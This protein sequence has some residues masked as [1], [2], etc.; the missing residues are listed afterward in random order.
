[1][2]PSG[3][4]A[5]LCQRIYRFPTP[6]RGPG[7]DGPQS[8]GQVIAGAHPRISWAESAIHIIYGHP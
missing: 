4:L 6:D 8:P 3:I 2:L 7:E 1:M 5:G